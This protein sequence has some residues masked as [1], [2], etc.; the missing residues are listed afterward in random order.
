MGSSAF[1]FQML[2]STNIGIDGGFGEDPKR[3]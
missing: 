2:D 3:L 1:G